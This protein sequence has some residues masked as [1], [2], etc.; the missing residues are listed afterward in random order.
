MAGSYDIYLQV[1]RLISLLGQA[2]CIKRKDPVEYN[3]NEEKIIFTI[4]AAFYANIVSN[5]ASFKAKK[6]GFPAIIAASLPAKAYLENLFDNT[7]LLDSYIVKGI[8]SNSL[9]IIDGY[10]IQ[11]VPAYENTIA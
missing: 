3:C 6:I 5:L 7:N 4:F 1:T 9:A 2:L 10:I 11:R 8:V